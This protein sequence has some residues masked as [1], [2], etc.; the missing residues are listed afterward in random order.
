MQEVQR[1]IKNNGDVLKQLFLQ[2]TESHTNGTDAADLMERIASSAEQQTELF[3]KLGTSLKYMET[4]FLLQSTAG[5]HSPEKET[6]DI[7]SVRLSSLMGEGLARSYKS[8][9]A[10][11]LEACWSVLNRMGSGARDLL[12]K[13]G[14]TKC[15]WTLA[16]PFVMESRSIRETWET[17]VEVG[18]ASWSAYLTK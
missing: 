8:P 4:P 12:D 3:V 7:T 10:Q 13:E 9:L 5:E 14:T 6:L 15:L 16:A 11:R 2:L 18:E 1:S 17:T